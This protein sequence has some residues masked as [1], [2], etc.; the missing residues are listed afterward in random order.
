MGRPCITVS[1]YIYDIHVYMSPRSIT[2]SCLTSRQLGQKRSLLHEPRPFSPPTRPP[3]KTARPCRSNPHA[4]PNVIW[5]GHV[6]RGVRH[7]RVAVAV[8]IGVEEGGLTGY[9]WP[10]LVGLPTQG[11][12]RSWNLTP[13][14]WSRRNQR[15]R[16]R[17]LGLGFRE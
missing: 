6:D 3:S 4:S 16:L 11:D 17:A 8:A 12:L 1:V 9:R 10:G 14:T 13:P 5:P 2:G 7:R 15:L